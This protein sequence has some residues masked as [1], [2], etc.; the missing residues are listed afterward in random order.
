MEISPLTYIDRKKKI[1]S[2]KERVVRER[3]GKRAGQKE[4]ERGKKER[5]RHGILNHSISLILEAF[6]I[7]LLPGRSSDSGGSTCRRL[8]INKPSSFW[9]IILHTLSLSCTPQRYLLFLF[10]PFR[11]ISLILWKWGPTKQPLGQLPTVCVWAAVPTVRTTHR[12]SVYHFRKED[13]DD[14]DDDDDDDEHEHA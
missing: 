1:W 14:D 11:I 6:H 7:T 8:R 13:G 10:I 9:G 3:V 4:R 5:K 2:R 12:S